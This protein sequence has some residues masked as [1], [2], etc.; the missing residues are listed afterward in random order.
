MQNR[1]NGLYAPLALE[2]PLASS[3]V[4]SRVYTKDEASLLPGYGP[5]SLGRVF[6]R[7]YKGCP[8]IPAFVT[9]S[10]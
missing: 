8:G 10:A 2:E 5:S 3:K 7:T 4:Y 9:E 1:Q 6:P